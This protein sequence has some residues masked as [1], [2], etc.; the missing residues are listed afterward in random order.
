MTAAVVLDTCDAALIDPQAQS[1]SAMSAPIPPV[2]AMTISDFSTAAVTHA[3]S[4]TDRKAT[5]KLN[6]IIK[7]VGNVWVCKR[8]NSKVS[9]HPAAPPPAAVP[10]LQYI[11]EH[12]TIKKGAA[13]AFL[14]TSTE[15]LGNSQRIRG[16]CDVQ[17]D[18]LEARPFLVIPRSMHQPG[19]MSTVSTWDTAVYHRGI[20]RWE[21]NRSGRPAASATTQGTTSQVVRD[22][23]LP[24]P[25]VDVE[26]VDCGS[27][28][29]SGRQ[30]P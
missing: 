9:D 1:Q 4:L 20:R 15:H 5:K 7:I 30:F 16:S 8:C 2:C 28:C 21:V 14:T 22:V 3:Q 6:S 10:F 25:T 27:V 11:D 24:S 17:R 23:F 18:A 12:F 29:T 13:K 26:H 19:S